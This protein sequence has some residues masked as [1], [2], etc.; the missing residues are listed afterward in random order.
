MTWGVPEERSDREQYHAKPSFEGALL[1]IGA[2]AVVTVLVQRWV[3]PEKGLDVGP[4]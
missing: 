2:G 1:L 3:I 4:L